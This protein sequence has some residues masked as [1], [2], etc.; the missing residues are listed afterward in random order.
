MMREFIDSFSLSGGIII[1]LSIFTMT[2]LVMV[3]FH[4]PEGADIWKM[5]A[6]ALTTF[7]SARKISDVEENAKLI[8][9][10][11]ALAQAQQPVVVQ[12]PPI[13]GQ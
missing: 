3:G 8:N 11:A 12:P 6:T 1:V 7:I 5:F 10:Q 9:A 4:H 13:P 2:G